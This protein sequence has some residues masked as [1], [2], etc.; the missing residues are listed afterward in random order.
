MQSVNIIILINLSEIGR[1]Y[2]K[3]LGLGPVHL[4][5]PNLNGLASP[6]LTWEGVCAVACAR[7][8]RNKDDDDGSVGVQVHCEQGR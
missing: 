4:L 3:S 2:R 5:I 7:C 6:L 1:G 8:S